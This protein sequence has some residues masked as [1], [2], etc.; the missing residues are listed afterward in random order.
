MRPLKHC[1]GASGQDVSAKKLAL[2]T[3]KKTSPEAGL[4]VDVGAA[5]QDAVE[6]TDE[7]TERPLRSGTQSS[8]PSFCCCRQAGVRQFD[9]V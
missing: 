3:V 6:R 1:S 5:D 9:P 2:H 4:L 8:H 7:V